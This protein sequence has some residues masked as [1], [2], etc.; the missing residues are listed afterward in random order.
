M[1]KAA[2]ILTLFIL[3]LSPLSAGGTQDIPGDDFFFADDVLPMKSS[4]RPFTEAPEGFPTLKELDFLRHYGAGPLQENFRMGYFESGGRKLAA[5]LFSPSA[6]ENQG[7]VYLL[8]GYLDHSLSNS[9]LIRL[10]VNHG[11]TVAAFDLPGHGLSEGESVDIG[12]FSEYAEALRDFTSLCEGPDL[13]E[14]L[15]EP[16][17][18]VAHSTGCSV[19]MEYLEDY[20]NSFEKIIFAAPL[21]YT[22]GG[23]FTELGLVIAEPFA[24]SVFRRFGGSTSNKNHEEFV[25][26]HDPLQSRSVPFS[27]IYAHQDWIDRILEIPESPGVVLNILQ[28]EEDSVVDYRDNI[29]FLLEKYPASRVFYFTD[30]EHSLFNEL[31]PVRMK[32][33]LQILDLLSSND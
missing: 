30:A 22:V 17:M 18:A 23:Q 6:G 19:V 16:R 24:D 28:G 1:K 8:H 29:E 11:Y 7:T 14:L 26:H 15:P 32:V 31:P 33:F 10:L 3:I 25:K 5:Y 20:G 13:E 21:V 4:L 27:W 9:R 2:S 12:D